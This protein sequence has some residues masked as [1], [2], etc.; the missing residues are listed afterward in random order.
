MDLNSCD[1]LRPYAL[2]TVG[3]MG[4]EK[5]RRQGERFRQHGIEEVGVPFCG[6]A[7]RGPEAGPWP[8]PGSRAKR[9]TAT[10]ANRRGEPSPV[11]LATP[12]AGCSVASPDAMSYFGACSAPRTSVPAQWPVQLR[13]SGSGIRSVDADEGVS[14][15]MGH[16]RTTRVDRP[17]D[18]AVYQGLPS[19][20]RA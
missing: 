3:E 10:L 4:T 19:S 6:R 17:D 16:L 2:T 1:L 14:Q 20:R 8:R 15:H 7:C 13:R 9:I 5:G 12:L 18:A 11:V